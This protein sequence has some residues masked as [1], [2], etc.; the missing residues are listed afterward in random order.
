MLGWVAAVNATE[1]PSQLKPALIHK[2][3]INASSA[4]TAA[5]LGMRHSF[6]GPGLAVS[7]AGIIRAPAFYSAGSR[8]TPGDMSCQRVLGTKPG[9][10]ELRS[11]SG[12]SRTIR[13]VL[14]RLSLRR[15]RLRRRDSPTARSPNIFQDQRLRREQDRSC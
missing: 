2:T 6:L 10:P 15:A 3:W 4:L 14:L 8:F 11:S 12:S 13:L 9:L 5:S 7:V 1:S